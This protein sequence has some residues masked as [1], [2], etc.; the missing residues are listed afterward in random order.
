MLGKNI[1]SREVH[2]VTGEAEMAADGGF[3]LQ[4]S[5]SF[6]LGGGAASCGREQCTEF[7]LYYKY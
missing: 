3:R 7:G 5:N 4:L 1:M 2:S 6:S